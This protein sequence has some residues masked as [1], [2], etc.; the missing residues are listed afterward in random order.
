MP[1]QIILREG[2]LKMGIKFECLLCPYRYPCFKH[3]ALGKFTKC[4]LEKEKKE[5]GRRNGRY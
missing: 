3:F 2:N 1:F 5:N 4:P